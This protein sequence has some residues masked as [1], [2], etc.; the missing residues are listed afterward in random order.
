[1]AHQVIR[2]VGAALLI[3]AVLTGC[4]K[5]TENTTETVTTSDTTV[6][7]TDFPVVNAPTPVTSSTTV[8]VPEMKPTGDVT[9]AVKPGDPSK[10]ASGVA[11]QMAPT[12]NLR[13]PYTPPATNSTRR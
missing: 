6:A 2:G 13:E 10:K 4:T 7:A 1:M 8:V 12:G 3:A 9:A 5:K 11:P